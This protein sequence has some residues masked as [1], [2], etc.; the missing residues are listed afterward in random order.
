M[1]F[2]LDP[3]PNT[4]ISEERL[5]KWYRD[6]MEV[7]DTGG[8]E[9]VLLTALQ[10]GSDENGL[11][12]MMSQAVTDH[13]YMNGG[14]AL[15]FHNKAFESLNYVGSEQRKYILASLVPM[16]GDAQRSEELYSWQS[17]VNLVQPLKEVFEELSRMGEVSAEKRIDDDELLQVLLGDDPFTTIRV[18]KEALFGGTSPVRI[19]QITALAAAERIVR[20]HTQN[21]FGDWI[22]VLHTFTHAH[23]V[24]ESLIRSSDPWIVRGIFHSAATIYLDRFLNIPPAPRPTVA[25]PS[26]PIPNSEELLDI[27]DKR[28]QVAQAGAWVTR[29]LRGGGEPEPLFNVLG[30]ALLREDADFHT[31]Q[32]YEAAL[33]EFDHW[34]SESGSFA[35]KARE[36]LILAITRYLAAHAPTARET[37][38]TARIAWRL[39]RGEKLFEEE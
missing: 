5:T 32:M 33:A 31:F 1:R 23:A 6:C 15:D 9:R 24:H 25:V 38:Q 2:L 22:S 10:S 17:P 14:H 7:R 39:H 34:S 11:F 28:Q 30:H 18:L 20:F 27:L 4:D 12:K 36:T 3:L 13:Y 19:A 21:D 26:D 35:E 8:A 37:P 16:F 29:Y